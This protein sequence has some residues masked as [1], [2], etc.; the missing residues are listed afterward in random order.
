MQTWPSPPAHGFADGSNRSS[1]HSI[2][3]VDDED[4]VRL[5]LVR[6]LE[7]IGYAVA[8]ARSAE[9]ALTR[10]DCNPAAVVLC[11]I[12]MPGHDGLWLAAKIRQHHPETA[13]IISSGVHDM[14]AASE[15]ARHGVVDYLLKPFGRDRLRDAVSRA[16][17]WHNAAW[18]ARRWRETL[19]REMDA[20]KASLWDH[21][22]R[23]PIS[24]EPELD[25]VLLSLPARARDVCEAATRVAALSLAIAE[26][27]ER[28]DIDRAVLRRAALVH[29]LGKLAL[30][31]AV[32]RKPAP[33]TPDEQALVRSVPHLTAEMLASISFL[34]TAAPIVRDVAE[35]L[36]G[37]GYPRG[38]RAELIPMESRIIAVADA[39]DAMTHARVYRDPISHQEAL[40]E[41]ERCA[42]SQFDPTVVRALEQT[43][44]QLSRSN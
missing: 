27:L 3:V 22:H 16:F 26:R 23:A 32:L 10:L 42:G 12:R 31:D 2:L 40:L 6:W 7:S 14:D 20:L 44:P 17:E 43:I 11:D 8:A 36:D 37:Q 38:I 15:S 5:L 35:R 25:A 9:E 19:E 41:L 28:S 21:V 13:V 39:Y 34:A 30:P 29:D 24:T 1:V 33:L 4:T 18:D